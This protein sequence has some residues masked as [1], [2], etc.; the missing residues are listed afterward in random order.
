MATAL[1]KFTILIAD[2]DRQLAGI[3]KN[4]LQ[5]MGFNNIHITQS[6]LDALSLLKTG[7]FDFLI[8]DWTLKDIDGIEL[9]TRIRRDPGSPNPTLPVI[10]LTGRMEQADVQRARDQGI[11]EYVVKPFTAKNI[12][13]RLERIVEFPRHFVIGKSFVGPDRRTRKTAEIT[14]ERRKIA[15]IAK[16]KPWE[17]AKAIQISDSPQLWMPDLT[18][19]NKLGRGVSLDKLITPALLAQAQSA[20]DSATDE[21]LTWIRE[22]LAELR[23]FSAA[24]RTMTEPGPVL[25]QTTD[26]ALSISGRAGTFGFTRGSEVAYMLYLF[27]RNKFQSTV[28]FHHTVIAKHTEVLQFI[29]GSGI[30]NETGDIMQIIAGLK[31]M[32]AK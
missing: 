1:Y 3:S 15:V 30:R 25:A 22:D 6:G 11:H 16:P 12:Y 14:V 20:I 24:L 28:D 23:H 27:L 32:A 7:D 5:G 9:I 21:S 13:N 18:L 4:M 10:M 26:I 31:S 17:S 8:T 2:Q 29:F 19:K